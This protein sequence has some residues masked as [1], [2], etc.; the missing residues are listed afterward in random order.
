[1]LCGWHPRRRGRPFTLQWISN[2]SWGKRINIHCLLGH[3]GSE[4][5]GW[6][7]E[8]QGLHKK[9]RYLPFNS[10]HPISH[11]MVL[12]EHYW[13]DVTWLWLRRRIE[14][15]RKNYKRCIEA[16]WLSVWSMRS[17]TKKMD[18]KSMQEVGKQMKGQE[19][20]KRWLFCRMYMYMVCQR[21]WLDH[22]EKRDE[23]GSDAT[24]HSQE[25]TSSSQR[26]A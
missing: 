6:Q 19:Q 1:M 14:Q 10:Y 17:V 9:T 21:K 22:Q 11:N 2:S 18:N 16:V 4:G 25:T 8:D 7:R 20:S 5:R 23:H 15:R 26:Q 24:Q 12:S 3:T 13:I